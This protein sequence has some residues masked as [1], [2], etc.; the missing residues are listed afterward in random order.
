MTFLTSGIALTAYGLA[1]IVRTARLVRSAI[2]TDG[3]IIEFEKESRN[4]RRVY[5]PIVVF[6]TDERERVE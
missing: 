1:K 2:E 6:F 5:V 4:R 3:T